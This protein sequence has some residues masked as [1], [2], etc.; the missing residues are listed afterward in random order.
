MPPPS[1]P[2][3]VLVEIQEYATLGCP[4][5][6]SVDSASDETR[7]P[8]YFFFSRG[9]GVNG[10]RWWWWWYGTMRLAVGAVILRLLCGAV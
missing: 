9:S 2:V 4:K 3:L 6:F 8:A 7:R 1:T 10:V 5:F